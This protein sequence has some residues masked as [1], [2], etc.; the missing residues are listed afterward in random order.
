M[1]FRLQVKLHSRMPEHKAQHPKRRPGEMPEISTSYN[2]AEKNHLI[3]Q[4]SYYL[5]GAQILFFL[6]E[7]GGRVEGQQHSQ[8]TSTSVTRRSGITLRK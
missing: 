3:E 2:V 1:A 7:G 6:I 8:P 5:Y 4:Q